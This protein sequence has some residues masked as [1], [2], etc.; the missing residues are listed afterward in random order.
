MASARAARPAWCKLA[1]VGHAPTL[2]AADQL[3]AVTRQFL[4]G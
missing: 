2:V 1:G 3:A 4:L